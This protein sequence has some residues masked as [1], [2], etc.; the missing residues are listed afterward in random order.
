MERNL[1]DRVA[2]DVRHVVQRARHHRG[3]HL[4]HLRPLRGQQ[5][6]RHS[7]D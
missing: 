3:G 1:V 4:P 2:G 5:G 6:E 7:S